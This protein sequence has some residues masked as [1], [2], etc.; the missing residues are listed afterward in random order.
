MDGRKRH[1]PS[2]SPSGSRG[3]LVPLCARTSGLVRVFRIR[4]SWLP[5]GSWNSSSLR[6]NPQPWSAGDPAGLGAPVAGG[7]RGEEGGPRNRFSANTPAERGSDG[8]SCQQEE[9]CSRYSSSLID[10]RIGLQQRKDCSW[11]A[12]RSQLGTAMQSRELVEPDHAM[13]SIGDPPEGDMHRGTCREDGSVGHTGPGLRGRQ[14]CSWT[15]SRSTLYSIRSRVD[16]RPAPFAS[17]G[18]FRQWNHRADG[19]VKPQWNDVT[20]SFTLALRWTMAAR[21]QGSVLPARSS[22]CDTRGDERRAPA[23]AWSVGF[24]ESVDAVVSRQRRIGVQ[25]LN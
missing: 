24:D 9:E 4:S 15:L 8:L 13:E 22:C 6:K 19:H 17:W 3:V 11:T 18:G 16:D 1:P 14:L 10:G 5:L 21:D 2:P 7:D 23:G 20:D 25:R 12:S